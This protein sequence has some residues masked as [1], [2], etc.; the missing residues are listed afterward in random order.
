M[1]E[2]ITRRTS[3]KST[4][5]AGTAVG[6]STLTTHAA[7]SKTVKVAL[8]GCGGRGKADLKNFQTACQILQ[9]DCEIV[10]L[11][12]AFEDAVIAA[13]NTFEVPADRCSFG[14]DAYH[15]VAASDA[16]FVLLVTP[17]LFRPLHLEA[18]LKAGKNV[19]V[20][21][22]VAVDAPGCRKVLELGKFATA[23]G[24]GISAGMQRRHAANYLKNQALVQ[25]GAIGPIL[26]GLVAWNGTVPWVKDRRPDW[27]DADYLARNWLNWVEIGGD[28]IVEQH[29][30]N[31]D[32]A[33]WFIG[34]PPKS[35]VGFG[36]RA[37][38][39]S[40]NSFD[41]FS[42]DLDYGDNVHI[43]SQCR[44][45][46]GCFNRVGEE[47][48][49]SKG[50][51]L[52][53]G[54]LVGDPSITVPDPKVDSDNDGVQEMIDMI[55]GVRSGNPLNEAQIVAEATGT[56]IMGRIACYTGKKIQWSDLFLNPK[57]EW[58][59]FTYGVSPEDFENGAVILPPENIAPIPGDGKPLRHR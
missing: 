54:K 53:G 51:V 10:A 20:E 21:K 23:N 26:G 41:F 36:G 1:A 7:Q 32:V 4:V 18:M 2:N 19:F 44:Q 22:P 25:A 9:L 13:A 3:L 11:A 16:D 35:A 43:H 6:L 15:N 58:Y 27:S 50:Y 8:V 47:F 28:H 42:V 38:R 31:L 30:H 33:N 45:I 24:L 46:S 57:S 59:D 48:R 5:L 39:E 52:G 14:F 17:P 34:H 49:G 40:G 37:R 56:A 55:R 12:D 29:V